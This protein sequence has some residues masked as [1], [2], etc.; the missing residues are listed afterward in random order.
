MPATRDARGDRPPALATGQ[1]WHAAG[2]GALLAATWFLWGALGRPHAL[3][4]WTAIAVPVAHQ[5]FVWLTWRVE[6][7]TGGVGRR[8]GFG[9]YLVLFFALFLGRFVSLGVLAWVDRG[10]LGLAAP[11]RTIATTVLLAPGLYAGYSVGRYFGPVR[12]AGADHFD[13]RYRQLPFVRE[14]IFR[15]TANGMY[16]FAFLLFWAMAVGWDSSAAL[17]AAA[18]GH[19]YI[20]VHYHATEKPDMA[21]LYG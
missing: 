14:G 21:Y 17:V 12:A 10:S 15:V 18:F 19:A 9:V 16:V 6:L 8:L 4:F 3:A 7:L 20:W 11:V 2:L 1:S 5:V 13:P